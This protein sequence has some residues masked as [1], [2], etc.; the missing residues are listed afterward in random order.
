M[1][2]AQRGA[3]HGSR[4]AWR[5][6]LAVP[7]R[8]YASRG[9][10]L[11][12]LSAVFLGCPRRRASKPAG[13]KTSGLLGPLSRVARVR[14]KLAALKQEGQGV[15]LPSAGVARPS[16]RLKKRVLRGGMELAAYKDT[17]KKAARALLGPSD[18]YAALRYCFE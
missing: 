18:L 11:G 16:R 7:R 4:C 13:T 10:G 14:C 3:A 15:M 8:L 17:S 1:A 9:S 2:G 12:V 6:C 5:L